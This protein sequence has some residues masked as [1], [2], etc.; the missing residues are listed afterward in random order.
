MVTVVIITQYYI[1][2]LKYTI[3]TALSYIILSQKFTCLNVVTFIAQIFTAAMY[4][5]F[6]TGSTTL[7]KKFLSVVTVVVIGTSMLKELGNTGPIL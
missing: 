1:G 2:C 3:S 7:I 5:T 6:P 4:F